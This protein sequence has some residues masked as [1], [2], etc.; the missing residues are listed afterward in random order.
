MK[1]VYTPNDYKELESDSK[2][3]QAAV[4]EAAKH[5][6]TV[7]IP[8]LNER[9]GE[10]LWLLDESI[11]LRSGSVVTL[12]NCHVRLADGTYIS[13]FENSVADDFGVWWK[14]KDR[15]Y[16][17]KLCGI[18]NAVL[19]GGNHNGLFESDFNLYDDQGNYLGKRNYLGFKGASINRGVKFRNVE[20]FSVSGIHFINQRYWAMSFEFC[21]FGHISDITFEA[22]ANVPNQDG[23]DIRVG[24]NNI[25]IENISGYTGDDMIAITNFGVNEDYDMD[26]DIH[27][28]IVKNIRSYESSSCDMIRILNRGGF[29]IYNIEISN[30]IDLTPVGGEKRPLAAVRIGDLN[31]YPARLN[32]PGE[33]R[34]ITVRD[35]IT[36]ARFGVYIANSITDSVI[37][38]VMLVGDAGIGMYFNGC[39]IRNLFVE[40]L[41]YSSTAEAS[42]SDVGYKHL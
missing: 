39:K 28:V 37:D 22:F 10:C 2:M 13:F 15:Q 38:N 41:A 11:K 17:I 1:N 24:C 12:D 20:R 26:P 31:N 35:V 7:V 33:T 14:K 23:I 19:D 9:T 27:D 36:R 4:D 3:I 21:S 40:R 8:R 29:K 34:N 25:L 16:D 30:V 18:G 6:A 32:E 5:G 42:A